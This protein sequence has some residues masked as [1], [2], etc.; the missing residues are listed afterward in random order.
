MRA[1]H[2]AFGSESETLHLNYRLETYH[3]LPWGQTP[4]LAARLAGGIRTTDRRGASRFV[5]GGVPEQNFVQAIVDSLRAGVRGYLR[6]YERRAA[7]GEQM[8]LLNLEYRQELWNIE[9]GLSTLPVFLRRVQFAGLLDAGDAFDGAI[10]LTRFKA[11][12]GASLRIY[13]VIGYFAPTAFDFGY[14]RGLTDG[15]INEW[16]ML[17][18]STI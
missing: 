12:L 7:V 16:W 9:R 17:L 3:R 13:T 1:D 18:T 6:G 10:D 11:S 8:H 2:P 5:I 4:V 14:S 15:G